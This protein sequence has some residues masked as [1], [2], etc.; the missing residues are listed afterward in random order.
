MPKY[1][2]QKPDAINCGTVAFANVLKWA[3]YKSWRGRKINRKF[4]DKTLPRWMLMERYKKQGVGVPMTEMGYR[5]SQV[6][7]LAVLAVNSPSFETISH[8][9]NYNGA[10]LLYYMIKYENHT[11]LAHI[12]LLIK[13]K[14]GTYRMINNSE[15]ET[16]KDVPYQQIVGLLKRSTVTYAYFL[17]RKKNG[18]KTKKVR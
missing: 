9:L 14:D 15:T 6:S 4:V 1:F 8:H 11:H 2:G 16:I 10:I 13:N 12:F 3:G 17:Q 7:N 18:K 5:L